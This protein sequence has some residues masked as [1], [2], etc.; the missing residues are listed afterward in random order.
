MAVTIKGRHPYRLCHAYRQIAIVGGWVKPFDDKHGT[1]AKLK[2]NNFHERKG[3][4]KKTGWVGKKLIVHLLISVTKWVWMASL[5]T[6][7]HFHT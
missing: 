6:P 2:N 7:S 4:D 3:A 1:V 5:I